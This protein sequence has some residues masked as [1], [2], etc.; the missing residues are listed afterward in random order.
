MNVDPETLIPKLPKPQELRPF[1]TT[2]AVEFIGH[3]EK[4]RTIS[5]NPTGQWLASGS[6]LA[7]M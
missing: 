4:V 7:H 6:I 2:L 5:V 3:N 1:P